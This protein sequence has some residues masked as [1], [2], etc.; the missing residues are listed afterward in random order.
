MTSI[1][2]SL[3]YKQIKLAKPLL[4]VMDIGDQ[5]KWQDR[6]GE[7]GAKSL[8]G[9]VEYRG[10]PFKLFDAEWA[11]P[12][13]DSREGAILYLHGGSYTAGS[14]PYSKGFGGIIAEETDL[15]TLCVGYRL[16]PEHPHPAA[17]EDALCAYRRVLESVSPKKLV[18]M[19]E[20]AGGG[21]TLALLL[22]IKQLKL[23][24]P[25]CAVT[26]SPWCDLTC[27]AESYITN[28]ERD[29][30]LDDAALRY[31][32]RCYA[33]ER[34]LTYPLVSPY[35]GDLTGLPPVLI[36]AGT[37]ELLMD[38]SRNIAEKLKAA[39]VESE[40]H[41]ADGMWHVYVLFSIPESKLAI[42]RI[43]SFIEQKLFPGE[44]Q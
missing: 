24:M 25:A 35:F 30:T 3:L 42:A 17:L 31:S 10:E 22:R 43:N 40:L 29:P 28:A 38:D 14:L 15:R 11:V 9:K 19:G 18:V 4:N 7:L 20:S 41:L 27:T 44:G 6:L 16:A 26:L 12:Q 5:R 23:P 37:F 34:P 32:A 2:G 21:L 36:F 13:Q 1:A 8:K 39:G 33:G